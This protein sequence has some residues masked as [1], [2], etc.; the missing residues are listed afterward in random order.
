[1]HECQT[2][3][4]KPKSLFHKIHILH[5]TTTSRS[6]YLILPLNC[7]QNHV[8]KTKQ[9]KK[10]ILWYKIYI[11]FI[12]RIHHFYKIF[13]ACRCCCCSFFHHTAFFLHGSKNDYPFSLILFCV[14]NFLSGR[15][16]SSSSFW[17][18]FFFYQVFVMYI[19]RILLVSVSWLGVTEGGFLRKLIFEKQYEVL[20]TRK[21]NRRQHRNIK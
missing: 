16:F 12:R 11:F 20:F 10:K 5:Y 9:T 14:W 13:I 19:L 15:Y 4:T 8:S 2:I 6:T 3:F 17:N 7:Y 21:S 18:F 1:M